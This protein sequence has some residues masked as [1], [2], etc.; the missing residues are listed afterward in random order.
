M[1]EFTDSGN[2]NQIHQGHLCYLLLSSRHCDTG[3]FERVTSTLVTKSWGLEV[4]Q[5]E[6][7]WYVLFLSMRPNEP[8]QL[9]HTLDTH[10][11]FYFLKEMKWNTVSCW[12]ALDLGWREEWLKSNT[13]FFK[14]V[15]IQPIQHES[16]W[17]AKETTRRHVCVGSHLREKHPGF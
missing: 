15:W 7:K 9:F 11:T 5:F 6:D 2:P 1:Y 3:V 12:R 16:P 4:W 17:K 13:I 8:V 10:K 14:C